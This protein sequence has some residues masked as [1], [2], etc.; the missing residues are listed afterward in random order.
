[1]ATKEEVESFLTTFLVKSRTFGIVFRGDRRKNIQAL[2]ELEIS[3]VQ[4]K[5]ELMTLA[6]SNYFEGP[7]E[8][9]LNGREDMWVFGKSIK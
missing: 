3:A 2:A 7:K 5:E 1:M 6:V 4:L 9:W 8:D